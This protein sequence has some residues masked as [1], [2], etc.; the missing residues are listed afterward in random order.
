[1]NRA[2]SIASNDLR[3]R[4]HLLTILLSALL[5]ALSCGG[6]RSFPTESGPYIV[7]ETEFEACH[8]PKP[9]PGRSQ[10]PFSAR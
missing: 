7:A 10:H 2:F 8:L 1:M 3:Q 6:S 5:F 9:D 4:N